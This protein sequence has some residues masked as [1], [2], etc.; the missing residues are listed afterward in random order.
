MLWVAIAGLGVLI[1]CFFATFRNA[2]RRTS[3]SSSGSDAGFVPIYGGDGG[4]DSVDCAPDSG[5]A[6]CGDAGGG[7]DG[8]GGGG[9]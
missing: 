9:D 8:G 2:P 3:D 7:G 5:G 6:D 1:L 4:G